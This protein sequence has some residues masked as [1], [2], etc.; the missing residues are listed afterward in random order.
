MKETHKVCYK[1]ALRE[2]QKTQG[3]EPDK[4]WQ[5]MLLLCTAIDQVII[6]C[7]RDLTNSP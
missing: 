1:R 6:L 4:Y 2:Y 3:L 5:Y 7:R